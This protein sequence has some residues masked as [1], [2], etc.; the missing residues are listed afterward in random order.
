MKLLFLTH[1]YPNYVPDLL[2][3]GLR[4]LLGPAAVEHPRK[5][6]LYQ[7]VLG[8]GVCPA[9]QLCPGWFPQDNG[10]IDRDDIPAKIS[11]GFFD[12][13]VAD[14]RAAG[15]W[16]PLLENSRSP[17]A[18]IDGEDR[19]VPIRPGRYVVF[20]RETAGADYSIPLPMALPEEIFN[21]I[22]AYDD[23][24]KTYSIGF[25][26]STHDGERHRFLEQLAARYPDALFS[27]SAVPSENNPLPPGRFGRDEYYRELQ[28][29]RIVLSL[30]GAG[31]DTFRFW[32][33]AACNA[34]HAAQQLPLFIPVDFTSEESILKFSG[35][36]Q[37][38]R[39]ADRVLD[40][41]LPAREFIAN[42]RLHLRQYHFTTARARYFLDGVKREFG[43][44]G[45]R[46]CR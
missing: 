10:Q 21:W 29:C 45:T 7:G 25:L 17:L 34:V 13:I 1:P 11:S 38:Q 26:G 23:Q 46:P 36:E 24:P 4:K 16:M 18:I 32:E 37:L 35:V 33:N 41:S 20:R 27:A 22:V 42:G 40:G 2:L 9:N 28:K 5:E 12:C 14:V 43:A 3:H 8:L 19:P 30:A 44:Q 15:Q 39:A 6:C 31:G